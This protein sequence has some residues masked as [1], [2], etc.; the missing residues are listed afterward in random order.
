MREGEIPL[1]WSGDVERRALGDSNCAL[2]LQQK[3]GY[4]YIIARV[5]LLR[6]RSWQHDWLHLHSLTVSIDNRQAITNRLSPL[7]SS[8]PKPPSE[9]EKEGYNPNTQPPQ[10]EYTQRENHIANKYAQHSNKYTQI[11]KLTLTH[12]CKHTHTNVYTLIHRHKYTRNHTLT[13]H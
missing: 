6:H 3:W 13:H 4:F 1:S 8:K 7:A 11:D 10:H 2:L 9:R 5:A 12:G